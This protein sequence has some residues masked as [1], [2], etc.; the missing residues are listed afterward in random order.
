MPKLTTIG[1][2]VKSLIGFCSAALH[3]PDG[4]AIFAIIINVLI[5]IA[6]ACAPYF[7]ATPLI[8]S[9]LMKSG[10]WAMNQSPSGIERQSVV[11]N[12]VWLIAAN[13]IS[14]FSLSLVNFQASDRSNTLQSDVVFRCVPEAMPL[15]SKID[16]KL[17][18]VRIITVIMLLILFLVIVYIFL[19]GPKT[20]VISVA[21]LCSGGLYMG[22]VLVNDVIGAT[23]IKDCQAI[24][25]LMETTIVEVPAGLQ[26][27]LVDKVTETQ[28]SLEF[29]RRVILFVDLPIMIGLG[30]VYFQEYAILTESP[31]RTGFSTG[32]V[33]MHITA[34]NLVSIV[35]SMFIFD[36]NK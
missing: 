30:V 10:L 24:R 34:A 7:H 23:A 20:H 33:A 3:R 32:A 21:S 6:A 5:L 15:A 8:D 4:Y 29:F 18:I 1:W 12:A 13:V 14:I 31:F 27:A 11:V 19:E 9:W 26:R 36:S 2:P 22:I 17:F 25:P 16:R 35:L 28:S